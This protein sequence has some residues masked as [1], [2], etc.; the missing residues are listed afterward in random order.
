MTASD[1]EI[2][3]VASASGATRTVA[4]CLIDYVRTLGVSTVFGVHGANIEHVFDAAT[5]SVGVTPVVAKH[6]F[7]AGAM[8]D[9]SARC[10][11]GYGV[12]VTTSGGGAMNVVPALAEAYD[13]RVPILA[14]IGTPPTPLVG[15]GGFQDMCTPPDT[16][17]LVAVMSGV[18]GACAVVSDPSRLDDALRRAC[19]ALADGYPAALLVPRDVQAAPAAVVLDGPVPVAADAA[20]HDRIGALARRLATQIRDGQTVCV[21]AGEEASYLQIADE[22]DSIAASLGSPIVVSPGGRDAITDPDRCAGVT[23]VMGHPSAHRALAEADLILAIGTRMSVTDRAGLDPVLASR[24]LIHLGRHRP[25]CPVVSANP[26]A[27]IIECVD[28]RETIGWLAKD[29]R[30]HTTPASIAVTIEN[31]ACP[32]P[33]SPKGLPTRAVIETIGAAL[34]SDSSVFADAGNTGAAAV[35]HLPFG[36]GRFVV[37]LGM[38]GMGYA[39]AAG[40]GQAIAST[41]TR[42]PGRTVVI[43]GDGAF[44][45]HGMEIHTAVEYDAPLTLVLLNNDAHGMCVT[46]EQQFFPTTPSV[47]RFRHTDFGAGLAALFPGLDVRAP[48]DIPSLAEACRELMA[49]PGPNCIVVDIDADE[50]PPFA[51]FLTRG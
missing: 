15:A 46:R 26:S 44:L 25:R 13:S 19:A 47:N 22:I 50:V 10:S 17:D 24:S 28:L 51:P 7:A 8:A 2:G 42:Q 30:G 29:L 14:I 9:G 4:D 1:P 41:H 18:V 40:V 32:T 48:A 5:R 3:E 6:E 23:G 35:H 39:I 49:A 20:L 11:G 45:M 12:V 33:E 16:I 31:L 43:A 38:G 27:E 36:G 34:G 37:A 21:W